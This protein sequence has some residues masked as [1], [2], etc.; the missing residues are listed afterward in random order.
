LDSSIGSGGW[1]SIWEP[2]NTRSAENI[3]YERPTCGEKKTSS[4]S[5]VQYGRQSDLQQFLIS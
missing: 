5:P 1:G 3:T 2:M 4:C